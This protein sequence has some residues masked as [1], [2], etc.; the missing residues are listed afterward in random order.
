MFEYALTDPARVSSPLDMRRFQDDVLRPALAA[1]P[2]VAE[3]ASVGGDLREVRIDVKPR[4][5]REHGLA[6]T[7]VLATLAPLFAAGDGVARTSLGELEALPRSELPAGPGAV[8]AWA[9]S[10]WSA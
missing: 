2:G 3:V 9:T 4:E 1:I 10:R 8:S 5:L 6:F 7:D